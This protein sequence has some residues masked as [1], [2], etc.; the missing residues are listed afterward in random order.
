MTKVVKTK[1]TGGLG[2]DALINGHHLVM[3]VAQE[4]GGEDAGPRPKPLLLAALTG[5]S[6]MDIVSILKKMQV[7]DYSFEMEADGEAVDE[8]PMMYHT[9]TVKFMFHGENLPQDKIIKAVN[10]ST[11]KYCAVNAML[12]ETAKVIAKIF[13]NDTEVQ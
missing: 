7:K 4:N 2:F 3:D 11:E 12:K 8:H 5:C 10:L 1:W 13:I 6:G 9:I